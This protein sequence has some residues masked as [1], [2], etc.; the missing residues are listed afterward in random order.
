[1]NLLFPPFEVLLDV[2]R[3]LE[4]LEPLD[5]EQCFQLIITNDDALVRRVGLQII[6]LDVRPEDLRER[7]SIVRLDARELRQRLCPFVLRSGLRIGLLLLL[8]WCFLCTEQSLSPIYTQ[9]PKLSEN[10]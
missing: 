6:R 1:M 9:F 7:K 8:F 3:Q 10:T 4:H 5:A 2:L